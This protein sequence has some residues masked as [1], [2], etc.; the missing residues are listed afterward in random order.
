MSSGRFS[1]AIV[2]AVIG[3]F[4]G[5]GLT[6]GTSAAKPLPNAPKVTKGASFE[7]RGSTSE[8]YVIN[9]EEGDRLMLV[10]RRGKVLRTGTADRF[11]SKIFYYMKP[12][13]NYTV[14]LRKDG[15]VY[16]SKRFNVRRPGANPPQSFYDSQTLQQGINY[17]TM[18]DGVKLAMTVRLPP[19]KTLAD[20]PFP[21]FI[22]Y[23]GYQVAAPAS[24]IDSV[25][26]GGAS[27]PL[28]P[29]T[30]TAVGSVLGPLL[31]YA[32]VSV[33][34]RGSGCSG[35][36]FDLFSLP[37]IY[38]GYDAVEAVAAQDWVKGGKV[39]MGG[40]SFSG[41]SQLHTAGTQPP[42]LA[43]I[44]P[45]S[46]TDD[47]YYATGYPGG[48]FNKGFAFS[49]I[50]QRGSDAEPAP[51]GGQEYARILSDPSS[52]DYDPRCAANQTLRLQTQD[53][54]S[55]IEKNRFRTP[56]VFK[57]RSPAFWIKRI[58]VP[59]FLVGSFQ[60]EQTGGHF[61]D[62]L[63]NFPK[64][65][66]NVWLNL[67]NGVH[68]DSLGPSTITRMVE[69]MDLFV[70]DRIPKIPALILALSPDLYEF[71]AD[72]PALPVQ[73][74]Q[75]ASYTDVN[76]A[77]ADFRKYP[78]VRLM[79]DNGAAVPGS[80]GAIGATWELDYNT[81]PIPSTQ[82]TTY[83]L[84]KGGKLNRARSRRLA[85]DAYTGDP[86]ARPPQTLNGAGEADS[87]VAQ[88]PYNWAPVADG[89]GLGYISAPMAKDVVIAGPSSLDLWVRSSARDT[90]IQ[91][92][93]TEVRPDG[94]ETLVQNGWLRA[95]HRKIYPGQSTVLSPVPTHLK[96]DARG[97]R[98]GKFELVRIPIY[99]FAHAFRAGSR[100]RIN[101]QAPG[102]DRQIWDFDTL[103]N[104]SIRNAIGL[105]GRYPSKIVLPVLKGATAKGTPLPVPTALRGQPSR[106]YETASNGG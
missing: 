28:A 63:K 7:A 71:L 87:W 41:I 27:N 84:G 81:W 103:E 53:F 6:V 105:G 15:E 30:S 12:G 4:A 66:R 20:G 100:I 22:E 95:S 86:S 88:P 75:F 2:V 56:A 45:L 10:D 19:G 43:A 42:H 51:E 14:R 91:A 96:K 54:D 76:K 59:T 97:M 62:S 11:G 64:S 29:A 80:P 101:I 5:M 102:G 98:K 55:V 65:N 50:S 89:K 85:V 49:W 52:P 94:K 48:I 37:T 33:Q 46:V 32:T 57:Y 104:G 9:A 68:A 61:V 21:T 3:L 24:L 36:A 92:T 79:M 93:I 25:I 67:Q 38:D 17:V 78:R 90:D 106:L 74:S 83:Y 35:G 18:R 13:A 99:Q 70:A 26:G 72:A 44:A 82:P 34:M 23:S 40:I 39:G 60:D 16:G 58:K 1:R 31:N 69:F 73:Q 47:M 8:A 77:R